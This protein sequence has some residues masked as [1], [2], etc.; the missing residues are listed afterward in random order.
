MKSSPANPLAPAKLC[1][2]QLEIVPTGSTLCCTKK[3]FLKK[4]SLS[5]F[6]EY[7]GHVLWWKG[8]VTND[9]S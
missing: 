8:I 4:E 1:A 6:L 5:F 7:D 3:Y 2:I 9:Y